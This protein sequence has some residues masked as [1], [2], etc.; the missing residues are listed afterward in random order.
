MTAKSPLVA[1]L[2]SLRSM[3][4]HTARCFARGG[5]LSRLR[6]KTVLVARRTHPGVGSS[7]TLVE[8]TSDDAAPGSCRLGN[9]SALENWVAQMEP[10]REYARALQ[11]RC[12]K[13]LIS[14]DLV[15][16]VVRSS[17]G[18][19]SRIL[20]APIVDRLNAVSDPRGLIGGTRRLLD[21]YRGQHTPNCSGPSTGPGRGTTTRRSAR[22][23]G[24]GG[25][26][27]TSH[28]G[29]NANARIQNINRGQRLTPN[30]N[31]RSN[32]RNQ[33]RRLKP[34]RSQKG[35]RRL[36][37]RRSRKVRSRSLSPSQIS[38]FQSTTT[39]H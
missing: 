19:H 24:L 13:S 16:Y 5:G 17:C 26:A 21:P 39:A 15:R 31:A 33:N 14:M 28:L 2:A 25:R 36:N 30:A 34:K 22:P 9:R 4:S 27:T 35:N 29:K 11:P 38:E 23:I 8:A 20:S 18:V 32:A 3:R 12:L 6:H 37:P 10:R 1:L 7:I